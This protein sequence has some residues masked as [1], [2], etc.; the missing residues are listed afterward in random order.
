MTAKERSPAAWQLG[1]DDAL[2]QRSYRCP[3]RMDAA[4]YSSGY[5]EGRAAADAA[6]ASLSSAV[7]AASPHGPPRPA[8]PQSKIGRQSAL[9]A[10][11]RAIIRADP[12]LR[13]L[14][15]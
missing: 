15:T 10:Q 13:G 14:L 7:I 12:V 3:L 9:S 1:Y 2:A 8:V 5:I 4:A 11:D 6:G